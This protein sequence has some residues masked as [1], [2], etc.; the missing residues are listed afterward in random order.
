M[1]TGNIQISQI[2]LYRAVQSQRYHHHKKDDRKKG[3]A[4]HICYGLWIRDEEQTWSWNIRWGQG[5]KCIITL[6][7][8]LFIVFFHWPLSLATSSTSTFLISA[9]YPSTVK[10]TNPDTKLVRQ[11]TK[12]VTMAS[13]LLE[14]IKCATQKLLLHFFGFIQFFFKSN[15]SFL[16]VV[17]QF[18]SV[19]LS[20]LKACQNFW[21]LLNG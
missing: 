18:S 16:S 15:F 5:E 19:L 12:L 1:C 11:F 6:K 4:H 8:F 14:E 20:T 3:W 2:F 17:L 21:H 10:I 13:L 7:F 9:M